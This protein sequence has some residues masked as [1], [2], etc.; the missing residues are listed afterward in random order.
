MDNSGWQGYQLPE[1]TEAEKVQ[2]RT[3]DGCG[4]FGLWRAR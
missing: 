1:P 3:G 4:L 2:W